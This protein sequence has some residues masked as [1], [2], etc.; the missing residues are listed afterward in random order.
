MIPGLVNIHCHADVEAGG[1]LI[2]DC[3]RRD[4]FQAGFLNYNAAPQ[5]VKNLPARQDPWIGGRFAL[6]ELLRNGCTT[7]VDIG[8]AAEEHAADRRRAGDARVP[9]ARPTSPYDYRV[10]R[11][12]RALY[13]LDEEAGLRGARPGQG[14]HP[15]APAAR[16]ADASRGCCSPSR[17][18]RAA[19][20]CCGR[21]ARRPTSWAWASRSTPARTSSSST[22]SCAATPDADR[23]PGRHGP[24]R[25]RRHRR[26]LHHQ[27]RA[28]PGRAARRARP[29]DPGARPA[30]RWPTARWCSPGAATRWSR[31]TASA[32]PAS[33]WGS[34][35]TPT[36]ATSSA[37]C[38]G[39]RCSARSSSTTSRWPPR[40][41]S[42]PPPRSAGPAALRRDDL[43]R[44]APGAKADIVLID[45]R[46]LPHRP[47]PRSDQG[48]RAVRHGRRRQPRHRGRAHGGG[49][50]PRRR[51][52]RGRSC[53]PTPS[54][55]PS[56]CGPR[57]PS[58]TGRS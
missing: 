45:M 11:A 36:R 46:K 25:P 51:G 40:P 38:A 1:R 5:G 8:V 20:R 52:R 31:S 17:S 50:R 7:V 48:P 4:F 53:W 3:G 27:L 44:L 33:T 57:S 22:R 19:R 28:P 35:P 14:L 16:T 21:P 42:S 6:V 58:G 12:R 37:R 10:R 15:Q 47:L 32:R 29:R 9:R 56:A 30:P 2:A 18:T 13:E 41:T 43:G 34:A 24:A 23:V 26:P 49:G 39:R 54:A 55:R